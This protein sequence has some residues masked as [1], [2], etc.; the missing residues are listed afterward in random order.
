MWRVDAC[1]VDVMCGLI[2]VIYSSLTCWKLLSQYFS[3]FNVPALF[4]Q[5]NLSSYYQLFVITSHFSS[6]TP[7]HVMIL[8]ITVWIVEV[9]EVNSQEKSFEFTK[10]MHL[11]DKGKVELLTVIYYF[12][13]CYM[14]S[15]ELDYRETQKK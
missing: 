13:T 3:K 15:K 12:E 9:N 6:T 11:A 7:Q 4:A 14:F 5:F 1:C 8:I 2:S 10:N